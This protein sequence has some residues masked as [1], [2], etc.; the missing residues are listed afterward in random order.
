MDMLLNQVLEIIG[1][2]VCLLTWPLLFPTFYSVIIA[3]MYVRRIDNFFAEQNYA[4]QTYEEISK[5]IQLQ[6]WRL[7]VV[8]QQLQRE[9]MFE[10]RFADESSHGCLRKDKLFSAD[11]VLLQYRPY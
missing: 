4:W 2:L 1:F 5:G 11:P 7:K 10:I 3:S 6:G 8:L 9:E